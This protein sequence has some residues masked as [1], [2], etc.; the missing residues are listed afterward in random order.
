MCEISDDFYLQRFSRRDKHKLLGVFM[1]TVRDKR[2][3]ESTHGNDKLVAG[4]CKDALSGVCT[5]FISDGFPNPSLDADGKL[6]F[7]L[8][9]QIKGYRNTDPSTRQQRPIPLELLEKMVRRPCTE[10]GL[11]AFHQ[12]TIF[13]FFFAMRSCEYLKTTG[14][15]RTNPLRL[16]HLVFRKDNKI[17]KHDDPNLELADNITITFE[18]Q[19]RDVR[20]DTVTQSRSGKPLVCPVR[21][22]A[23]I[24][25][26]LLALGGKPSTHLYQ[27]VDKKG[28]WK[29]LTATKAVSH[30]Q[31]FA[32]TLDESYG[33]PEKFVGTHSIR[34]S[35]AMAMYLN[36][37]PV[38]TIMLL[39]RWS[40]DA[41]LRYIRRQVTEFSNNVARK[42]TKK[43]VYHH[44]TDA[45]REDPRTHNSMAAS[46]NMGLGNNL[47]AINRNTF[48][49]WV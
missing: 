22:A 29:N 18:Y 3:S 6:A 19:K 35:G 31:N 46:A 1:Q 12:L 10:P 41:F 17:V 47:P 11:I 28:K 13:A 15:R 33:L 44:I 8:Q 27:Y 40:S 25:K 43:T 48:S 16:E 21:A 2:F 32:K 26:R 30:L 38:Y 24:V 37:I 4:T 45:D 14:E 36:G 7:I 42:M 20:N 9:R 49:V 39:G 23:A 5:A 34:S